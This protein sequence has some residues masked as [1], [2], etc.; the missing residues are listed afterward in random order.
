M[1]KLLLFLLLLPMVPSCK[2]DH[3]KEECTYKTCYDI[4]AVGIQ[5]DGTFIFYLR[6][7]PVSYVVDSLHTTA[8][9]ASQY[10][11]VY[12]CKRN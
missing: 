11:F 4:A 12:P 6:N 8:Y 1:N 5:L 10:C 9:D 2:K 3:S 7:A